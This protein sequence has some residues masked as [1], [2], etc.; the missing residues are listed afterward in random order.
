MRYLSLLF[1]V[2]LLMFGADPKTKPSAQAER[3]RE[4]FLKSAKG[5]PCGTCHTMIGLGTQVGPDLTQI[6]T[7]AMPRGLV[8]AMKPT[9]TETVMVVKPVTGETFAGVLKQ[10]TGETIEVWDVTQ[11]PPV[12][13]TFASKDVESMKRDEKWKHP[14]ALAG[15]ETSEFA[16]IVA[17]LKWAATGT[18]KEISLEDI[19]TSK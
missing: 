10:K 7:Y 16:D 2:P 8:Q 11:N 18:T 9:M 14:A 13:R 6:A 15:Y 5:K 1:V 4:L 3:G 17:F 12:L 19:E